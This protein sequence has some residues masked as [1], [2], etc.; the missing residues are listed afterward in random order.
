MAR[1]QS[2]RMCSPPV[3]SKNSTPRFVSSSR[4]HGVV[5]VPPLR[6]EA[7][8][9]GGE[10]RQFVEAVA[11]EAVL[12]FRS[13]AVE[14]SRRI[15]AGTGSLGRKRLDPEGDHGTTIRGDLY[16]LPGLLCGAGGCGHM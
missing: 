13:P 7:R 1:S 10:A 11:V 4:G 9:A 14:I 6:L 12:P 2:F 15:V 8:Q 16:P 3:R 5:R